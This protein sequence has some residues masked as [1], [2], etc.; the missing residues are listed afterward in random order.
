V[1]A[2]ALRSQVPETGISGD[3]YMTPTQT[4][5]T[6]NKGNPKS[7]KNNHTFASSLILPT[8][9]AFNAPLMEHSWDLF[10]M[11]LMLIMKC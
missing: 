1:I 8:R 4:F 9:V 11:K 5:S 3:H 7:L 10:D 2:E 6:K